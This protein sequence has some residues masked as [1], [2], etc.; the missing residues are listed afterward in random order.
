MDDGTF[1][2]LVQIAE[3]LKERMEQT[4]VSVPELSRRSGVSEPRIRRVLRAQNSRLDLGTVTKLS[5]RLGLKV[6]FKAEDLFRSGIRRGLETVRKERE[7]KNPLSEF[8]ERY[9][10]EAPVA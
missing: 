9:K 6:E 2:F 8:K 1:R 4:G 10:V 7:T 3:T 5:S